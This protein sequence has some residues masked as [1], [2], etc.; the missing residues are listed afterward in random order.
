MFNLKQAKQ[1]L[2]TKIIGHKIYH[3]PSIDSTNKYLKKIAINNSEGVVVIADEQTSGRGRL[4]RNWYS[5]ADGGL[6][7]SILLQ[8]TIAPQYTPLLTAT[9]SLALFDLLKSK[10][11]PV[12]IKWPNDIMVMGKKLAG[13]LAESKMQA[14]EFAYVV[15][16]IGLNIKQ[17]VFPPEIENIAISL[18]QLNNENCER[19]YLLA[20][21]LNFFEKY[22]FLLNGGEYTKLVKLWK[23]RLDLIGQEVKIIEAGKNINGIVENISQLGEIVIRTTDG[24]V[25]IFRAGD[26]SLRNIY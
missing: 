16:G 13:I 26:V 25:Q 9:A 24:K 6:W 5:P 8:P 3:F 15:L 20:E 10:N 17:T 22:Y 11:I 18:E 14:N 12:E 23:N 4:Q 21:F 7:F 2:D 19:E 1:L